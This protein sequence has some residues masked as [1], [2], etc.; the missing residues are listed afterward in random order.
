MK[1]LFAK[2]NARHPGPS[3][4]AEIFNPD[5]L[6]LGWGSDGGLE[7]PLCQEII[8]QLGEGCTFH[9]D[10]LCQALDLTSAVLLWGGPT[11]GQLS[12]YRAATQRK[13]LEAGPFVLGAGVTGAVL[14]SNEELSVAPMR[15]ASPTLPYYATNQGVGS[16]MVIRLP[17]PQSTSQLH[18]LALLCVDRKA[19]DSWTEQERRLIHATAGRLAIDIKQARTLYASDRERHA[20]RRAFEGLQKLNSA[21]GLKS[22]FKATS[23][24]IR[25]VVPADFIA[26][27]LVEKSRHRLVYVEG[28]NADQLQGE[29]FPRDQGLVGQVLKYAA[30]LPEDAD[31]SGTSPVFSA[32]HLFAEYRSLMILPLLQDEGPPVGALIVA[33]RAPDVFS[34]TCRKILEL[35]A[36]QV[37]IK[38]DLAHSHEQL[39]RMATIDSLTGIANR[40]AYQK[41]FEAMLDRAKRR[42]GALYLVLCDID[43]FKQ[44]NDNYG[45]PFGDEVL[46]QVARLFEAVVRAVDLAAR[47]GGE[48][49]AIL[50]EDADRLGAMKVAERLR[51]LVEELQLS[52][53][54]Q[55]VAVTISLGIAAFPKDGD[56]VERLVS[57]ADKALYQAKKAGRNRTVVWG[58]PPR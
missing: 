32:A 2:L 14:K 35:M 41:G 11:P 55:R 10:M 16:C 3:D 57:C 40:R 44:I 26:I 22:A 54:G 36:A 13:D 48:E 33:A 38:I 52:Y 8:Q 28:E 17:L 25:S 23:M 56:S 27:S 45:H 50:L 6:P 47:T 4:N 46:R 7:A 30:T 21:L 19:P 43:H 53:L 31:Y 20:Y 39:N 49:F 15:P 58:D 9:L 37:A 51:G 12:L 29:T 5:E 34:R 18:D 1:R 24:A 42:H